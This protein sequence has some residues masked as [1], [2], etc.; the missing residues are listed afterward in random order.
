MPHN[1]DDLNAQAREVAIT[2]HNAQERSGERDLVATAHQ[3]VAELSEQY[4]ELCASLGDA[5]KMK[6]ER[7]LGRR[8]TDIRRLASSLPRIGTIAGS[9]PDRQVHGPSTAGERRITGV[10]WQ[11]GAR[12]APPPSQLR[13]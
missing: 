8:I 5:E 11:A 6:V 7:T 10:S 1:I 13:V 12:H 9:T 3:K 4:R 2:V